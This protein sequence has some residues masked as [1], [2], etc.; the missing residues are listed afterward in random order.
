M[1]GHEAA[2]A[3]L[4]LRELPASDLARSRCDGCAAALVW[5]I[6]VAGPNGRGGK[7]MP[8]DP[9]EDLAG[10]VQ[11]TVPRLGRLEARVL[12]RDESLERSR[13][14]YAAMPHFATCPA[15][16]RP[17]LPVALVSAIE[18]TRAAAA[19]RGRRRRGGLVG[20][21]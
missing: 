4:E 10:N 14:E 8:L 1:T 20:A 13:Y 16:C 12:T 7:L 21:R 3:E 15:R 11:V 18:D 2:A 19:R 5:A 17:S 6:T 9:I